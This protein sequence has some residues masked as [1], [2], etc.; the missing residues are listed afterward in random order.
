MSGQRNERTFDP[1]RTYSKPSASLGSQIWYNVP[2]RRQQVAPRSRQTELIGKVA[3]MVI[4][5]IER[6]P[7]RLCVGD[8]L[9]DLSNV[10]QKGLRAQRHLKD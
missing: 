1:L 5:R 8:E 3:A 4:A 2:S 6:K 9:Q 7:E 10:V